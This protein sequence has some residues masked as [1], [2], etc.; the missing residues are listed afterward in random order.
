MKVTA[1]GGGS[2]YTPELVSGF[3]ARTA[4]F[5][6]SELWLMDVSLERLEVVSGF[7]QRMVE[8]RGAPFKVCLT[9]DLDQ[10]VRGAAYVIT[11]LRVGM[12]AARRADEYLGRRHGLIGQETAGVGGMAKALRTIP[13]ILNIA[14]RMRELAP[15]ALLANFTNPAGL[16]VEALSRYAADVPSVGVCNVPM[17]T[18][19]DLLNEAFIQL[20]GARDADDLLEGITLEKYHLDATTARAVF[21]VAGEGDVVGCQVIEWAGC[22]L[23]RLAIGVIRQLNFEPL[24]FDAVRVGSLFDGGPLLSEPMFRA[25]RAAAPGVRFLRL[26]APPASAA[27]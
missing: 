12:M 17:T 18:K 10:S 27:S 9:T 15:G 26:S 6:L 4:S 3:I 13:V 22:E 2:T 16:V 24:D 8:A 25:V 5:P 14:D 20:T 19:M 23:A 7:V 11:Q 21:R 1:V